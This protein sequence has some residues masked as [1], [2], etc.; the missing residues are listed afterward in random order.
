[1]SAETYFLGQ[2]ASYW[3]ELQKRAN[4]LEVSRLMREIADL[5]AKV[6]FYELR[7]DEIQRFRA[8]LAKRKEEA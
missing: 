5:A 8:T 1:M 7:M 4:S 6:Q 2:P 3:L